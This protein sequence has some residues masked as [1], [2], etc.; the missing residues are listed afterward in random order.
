M[1]AGMVMLFFLMVY[2]FHYDH[3]EHIN[4]EAHPNSEEW[5]KNFLKAGIPTEISD[6]ITHDDDTWYYNGS[7]TCVGY[8]DWNDKCPRHEVYCGGGKKIGSIS[9]QAAS[10]YQAL[11]NGGRHPKCPLM[12]PGAN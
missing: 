9:Q 8:G 11:K 1:L 4:D 7:S 3:K 2:G 5:M 12:Y 6:D 10:V